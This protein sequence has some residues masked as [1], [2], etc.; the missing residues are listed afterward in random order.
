MLG[1]KRLRDNTI[2]KVSQHNLDVYPL[3]KRHNTPSHGIPRD[4]PKKAL[5]PLRPHN[6]DIA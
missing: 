5:D 4:N 1:H 2:Q 3:L 6:R